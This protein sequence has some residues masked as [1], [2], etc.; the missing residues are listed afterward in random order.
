MVMRSCD[1]P[2]NFNEELEL[3]NMKERNIFDELIVKLYD[4][5]YIKVDVAGL[6]PDELCDSVIQRIK[7]D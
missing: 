6:N 5:T 2:A 7:P 1:N 3:Y 4:S